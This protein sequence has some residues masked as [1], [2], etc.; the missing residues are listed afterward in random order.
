MKRINQYNTKE[1]TKILETYED[2]KMVCKLIEYSNS[3]EIYEYED[4][5]EICYTTFFSNGDIKYQ[6]RTNE[7]EIIEDFTITNLRKVTIF[8]DDIKIVR[9]FKMNNNK[10][11][12]IITYSDLY[13]YS[14]DYLDGRIKE[15]FQDGN[16]Y[17]YELYQDGILKESYQKTITDTGYMINTIFHDTGHEI[18]I[19]KENNKILISSLKRRVE[20]L[21]LDKKI[22][23]KLVTIIKEGEEFTII[24]KYK[25]YMPKM[26]LMKKI[27]DDPITNKRVIETFQYKGNQR[28]MIS[29]IN[30]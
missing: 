30:Y 14:I 1:G 6:R 11:L 28:I 19:L 27:Y 16:N 8:C 18:N 2:N 10:L 23:T 4:G 13:N 15:V 26:R 21:D 12:N 17:N 25:N 9:T 3:K 22:V 5:R 7:N 29:S 20:I 24:Y